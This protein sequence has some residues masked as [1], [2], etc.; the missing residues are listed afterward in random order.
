AKLIEPTAER[1]LTATGMVIG[2]PHY[3]APEQ[4]LGQP[5]DHSADVYALGV[6]LYR[7][8]AGRMPFT[9]SGFAEIVAQHMTVVPRRPSEHVGLPQTLDALIM[10]CLQKEAE[11]RPASAAEVGARLRDALA[12]APEMSSGIRPK[13]APATDPPNSVVFTTDVPGRRRYGW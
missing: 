6:I 1:G 11:R 13:A 3:M 5:V 10:D 8:F 9:G 7:V 4:C 2:T 12:D